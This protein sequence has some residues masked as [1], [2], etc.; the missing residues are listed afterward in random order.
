MISIS[1]K[2]KRTLFVI[3]GTLFLIIGFIGVVIPVL[4]TTPFLL[5]AAACYIRGSKRIHNWMINNSIFG[6]FVKNYMERKGIT[7]KQKIITLMF[8]WLTIII[9]IYYL[10]DS[11]PITIALFVI[12]IAVSAHILRIRTL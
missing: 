6:D 10:I 9:S 11:I 4:P 12:A 7:V 2:V 8:L 1:D 5:L 3:I